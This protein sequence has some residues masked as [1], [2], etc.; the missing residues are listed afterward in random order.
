MRLTTHTQRSYFVAVVGY[1]QPD[2][3]VAAAV[4]ELSTEVLGR[5]PEKMAARDER[6]WWLDD[7]VV[8]E[9]M[10]AGGAGSPDGARSLNRLKKEKVEDS[11]REVIRYEIHTGRMLGCMK[12]WGHMQPRQFQPHQQSLFQNE[13]T[14]S[15]AQLEKKETME[16]MLAATLRIQLAD[17]SVKYPRGIMENMLVKRALIDVFDGKL[18]F[19][20]DDDTITFDIKK[21]MRHTKGHDDT[22]YFIDTFMSHVGRCLQE[23]CEKDT[24]DTQILSMM[25]QEVVMTDSS[26][27]QESSDLDSNPPH[28]EKVFEVIERKEPEV[29]PSVVEPPSLEL[30]ELPSHLKYAF[31][32]DDSKLLVIIAKNLTVEEKERLLKVLRKH[33]Q[34][35]AWKIM[36]I[37]GINPTFCTHKILMEDE[38]KPVVQHQRRLNPNMQEVVVPKKGGMTVFANEKNELIPTRTVMGWRACID[39]RKL[40]DA[41]RYFQIPITLEDQEK[42]TFKCPFGTFAYRRMPFGLCNAPATFQRCMVAIFRDMIEDSMEVFMDDFSVFGDSFDKCLHSL[43]CML[44]R[45]EETNLLLNWE[46]C[47]VMVREGNVLGHKISQQGLEVDRAKV[48]TIARLPPPTSVKAIRIFLEFQKRSS[49]ILTTFTRVTSNVNCPHGD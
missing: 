4:P 10:M 24:L 25:N 19:R 18:T 38:Y 33:K 14:S 1:A 34:A 39:C 47:H 43:E 12:I 13:G 29:K 16:E 15:S 32:D 6:M 20:V 11:A 31:L 8:E 17:R 49:P 23:I 26:F 37:K 36:D 7:V 21:S 46:K 2:G 45:C 40:N 30:K 42:T 22:L 44:A 3:G 27:E 35:I 5:L 28:D 48:E 41:T 9:M